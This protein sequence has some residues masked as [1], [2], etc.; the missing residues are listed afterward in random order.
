MVQRKSAWVTVTP[1]LAKQLRLGDKATV[2]FNTTFMEDL[3]NV[4][5]TIKD[6]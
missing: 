1:E 3:E 6:L 2:I 4:G 5:Q